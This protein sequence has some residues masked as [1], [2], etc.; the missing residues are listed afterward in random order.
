MC[1]KCLHCPVFVISCSVCWN[2]EHSRV[3]TLVPSLLRCAEHSEGVVS[4]GT[5][6]L[7]QGGG[8]ELCL[9]C[10]MLQDC[11]YS[12]DLICLCN[13]LGL[14]CSSPSL[15]PTSSDLIL[16]VT[17]YKKLSLIHQSGE[18]CTVVQV[19]HCTKVPYLTES[20]A[21]WICLFIKT[22]LRI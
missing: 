21:S 7:G 1:F 3:C 4:G 17:S 14:L 13:F 19:V 22:V 10:A 12:L 11:S 15:W 2:A 5:H 20:L 8:R 18:G 6:Y 9:G 16:D